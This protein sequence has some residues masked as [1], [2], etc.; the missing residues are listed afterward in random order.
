QMAA[1]NADYEDRNRRIQ[2]MAQQGMFEQR[3]QGNYAVPNQSVTND[4]N[5]QIG[6]S[7]PVWIGERLVLARRV[8]QAGKTLVQGCWLDWPKLKTRLLAEA[9]DLMPGADLVPVPTDID[10]DP[11][12]MLAGLPVRLVM[13]G[14]PAAASAISPTLRW[15]LW[16]GWGALVLAAGAAAA[17]LGG[18]MALSERRAS[19]VSSVTHELRTPLTTFRMYSEMLARGMVP[20]AQRRQEYLHTLQR[21]AERLTH[22]VENVLAYARLERGRRPNATDRPTPATL[23]DRIGPRL[24]QRA[25]HAGMVCEI[26][27]NPSAADLAFTT[28]QGVVEQILFNLVDN[29]AKYACTADDRRIH[30][31]ADRNGRWLEFT[32]CDHGPGMPPRRRPSR[33]RPFAKSAEE[34]AETAPGVGLGLA[35]CARLARQLGGRLEIASA[36]DG[37]AIVSLFLPVDA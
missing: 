12:R 34:S 6:V 11:G 27:V 17:L 14:T 16:I 29:A 5:T 9:V 13:N 3:Q 15:A 18:V 36:A 19:F 33:I 35:L 25:E 21:E 32:V 10:V 30:V 8:E 24:A 28:D 26:E 37:G 1:R 22:L 31:A 4:S 7:R 23:L 2:S 20:D